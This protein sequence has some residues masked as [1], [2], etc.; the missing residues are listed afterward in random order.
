MRASIDMAGTSRSTDAVDFAALIG[1]AA[2]HRL[3]PAIRRRFRVGHAA[4][5]VRYP[6][7]LRF[8]RNG[9]GLVFALLSKLCGGPLPTACDRE[10][11]AVVTVADD[12][13][14]GV[15]WDRSIRPDDGPVRTIRSVKRVDSRGRLLECVRGGLGM[16]LTVCERDGALVFASRRYFLAL[17]P[18]R[19]PLPHLLTPGR[20]EVTHRDEGGGR[21]RF[22]LSMRH[23]L[24]GATFDQT[25]L[26]EDPD[27]RPGAAPGRRS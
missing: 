20:C 22:T 25:G 13:A 6:G 9:A 12:G 16:V 3:H 19:L 14:G 4:S 5:P 27:D 8:E 10:W 18:L 11:P 2:W 15:I 1:H 26:F 23:P 24:W 7:R 21:F 17:G